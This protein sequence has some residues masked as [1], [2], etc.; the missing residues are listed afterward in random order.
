M[1]KCLWNPIF[2]PDGE[3]NGHNNPHCVP[4]NNLG[5]TIFAVESKGK[6]VIYTDKKEYI[7]F[8]TIPKEG[9]IKINLNELVDDNLDIKRPNIISWFYDQEERTKLMTYWIS[10]TPSGQITGDHAF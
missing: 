5:P 10:Y 2:P 4:F 7:S 3:C 9:A 8:H 6:L 1:A